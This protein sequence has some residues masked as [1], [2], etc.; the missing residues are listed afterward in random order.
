MFRCRDH[1]ILV[2]LMDNL[3]GKFPTEGGMG[4]WGVGIREVIGVWI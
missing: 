2:T 4:Y 3:P 1:L